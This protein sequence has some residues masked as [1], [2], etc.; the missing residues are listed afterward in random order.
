MTKKEIERLVAELAEGITS[1]LN[2]NLVDV[3]FVKEGAN[4]ILRVFIDKAGGITIE[5]CQSVSEKLSV[6]LDKADPIKQ[7]YFLEVSSPGLDRPL[8]TDRDFE[9]YKGEDVEVKLYE[10]VGGRKIFEGTLMG[11]KDGIITV[12]TAEG[13]LSFDRDKVATVRRTIKF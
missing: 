10:P 3:E 9:R 11:L 2:F 7:R 6:E 8:K 12:E 5:D 1:S 13:L 4:W